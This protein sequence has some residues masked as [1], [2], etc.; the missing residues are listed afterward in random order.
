MFVWVFLYNAVF[1]DVLVFGVDCSGGAVGVS[2][3]VPQVR[4]VGDAPVALM[5]VSSCTSTND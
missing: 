4:C 2:G 3:A 5:K 1:S